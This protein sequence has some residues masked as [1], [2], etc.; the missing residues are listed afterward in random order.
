VRVGDSIEVCEAGDPQRRITE[1]IRLDPF[2]E[3]IGSRTPR[4]GKGQRHCEMCEL[5]FYTMSLSCPIC[6]ARMRT[7]PKRGKAARYIDP[8]KYGLEP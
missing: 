6:G 4:Y 5:A 1:Y 8:E 2:S 3:V 7:E